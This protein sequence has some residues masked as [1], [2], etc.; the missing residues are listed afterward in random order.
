MTQ[1]WKTY[2]PVWQFLLVFFGTYISFSGL[3]FFA[4]EYWIEQGLLVDPIIR[5]VGRQVEWFLKFFG[6]Q[7]H[8]GPWSGTQNLVISIMNQP[9]A[10]LVEGCNALS[11]LI[12]FS[13]FILAIP[14]KIAPTLGY[15]LIGSILIYAVNIIRIVLISIGIFNYPNW[16]GLLHDIVFPSIIYGTVL[17]LWIVW[18]WRYKLKFRPHD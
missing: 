4:L 16:T 11:I 3:Y 9:V 12:L 5:S 6:Y 13:A 1:L 14:Q 8:I 15:V 10:Q 2:R 7:G 18:V 17:A